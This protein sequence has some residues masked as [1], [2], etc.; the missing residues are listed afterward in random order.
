MPT[1]TCQGMLERLAL[2]LVIL[3][4][5]VVVSHRG[6]PLHAGRERREPR[7]LG[8]EFSGEFGELCQKSRYEESHEGRGAANETASA[9]REHLG[10]RLLSKHDDGGI[11]TEA[12][13]CRE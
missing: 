12:S 6:R 10:V 8:H 9:F 13:N 3:G 4:D 2:L 7:V 5:L 11:Q 1:W